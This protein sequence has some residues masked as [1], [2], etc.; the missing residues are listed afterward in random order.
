MTRAPAAVADRAVRSTLPPSTTIT[1]AAPASRA[2]AIARA[3]QSSSL[4]AGMITETGIWGDD[5]RWPIA[6]GCWPGGTANGQRRT[7]NDEG[8]HPRRRRIKAHGQAEA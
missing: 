4:S 5:I 6:V 1:S 8:V 3:I 2:E 7:A